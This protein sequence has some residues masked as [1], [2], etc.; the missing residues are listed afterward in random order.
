MD[1]QEKIILTV[2]IVLIA[3]LFIYFS[4]LPISSEDDL[5]TGG[6]L[7][8][9]E[10]DNYQNTNKLH[11]GHIPITYKFENECRERQINLTK[12]AFKQIGI[13]TDWKVSFNKV[14]ENPD[15]S[16]YC[17]PTEWKRDSDLTLGDAV[18]EVDDYNKNL[19]T[20]AEINFYGQGQVCATGYPALEVHEILH[21]FGFRDTV[22]LNKIISR[23][24]AESTR[25]C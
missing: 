7:S 15:I 17:K 2:T 3:S 8:D 6:I 21:T 25:K 23:Y 12:L 5:L 14:D 16:I 10:E 18:Y 24:A 9:L 19:V 20:H 13:E 4:S 11:W 22:I 1:K